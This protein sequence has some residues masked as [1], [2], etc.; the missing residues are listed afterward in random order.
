MKR[1]RHRSGETDENSLKRTKILRYL[2]ISVIAL[3]FVVA[4]IFGVTAHNS[5]N[6]STPPTAWPLHSLGIGIVTTSKGMGGS[7]TLTCAIDVGHEFSK[8]YARGV[9]RSNSKNLQG[10]ALVIGKGMRLEGQLA[11]DHPFSPRSATTS[12]NQCLPS[13]NHS[14]DCTTNTNDLT[15]NAI[16]NGMISSP[17]NTKGA[18]FNWGQIAVGSVQ[19]DKISFLRRS[20]QPITQLASAVGKCVESNSSTHCFLGNQPP[21]FTLGNSF[22]VQIEARTTRLE[23]A[24]GGAIDGQSPQMGVPAFIQSSVY[25]D[26]PLTY[27]LRRSSGYLPQLWKSLGQKS[28][29]DDHARDPIPL[30]GL[31]DA[32]YQFDAVSSI[33]VDNQLQTSL[34]QSYQ[35]PWNLSFTERAPFEAIWSATDKARLA[36]L[37]KLNFLA[38]IAIGVASSALVLLVQ[39]LFNVAEILKPSRRRLIRRLGFTRLGGTQRETDA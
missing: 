35:P 7:L 31:H 17:G 6:E 2:E 14:T 39:L 21:D 15:F 13:A 19:S 22:G 16:N 36:Q 29:Y 23:R 18:L 20:G 32:T 10:F 11:L 4:T 3:V 28:K 30:Y 37:N 26:V 8:C 25:G 38:G 1:N 5:A 12:F 34:T 33:L 24:S 9:L 27:L